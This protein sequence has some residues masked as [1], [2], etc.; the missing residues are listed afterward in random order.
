MTASPI[1]I[2]PLILICLS[3]WRLA[4]ILVIDDFPPTEWLRERALANKPEGWLASIFNCIWCS[5]VW[6]GIGWTSM[7]WIAVDVGSTWLVAPW[8]I[9]A[10]G[11]S[12]SMVASAFAEMLPD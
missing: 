6:I 2:V 4:H 9:I 11:L 12:A 3:T 10:A 5:S 8:Y 1:G 7:W